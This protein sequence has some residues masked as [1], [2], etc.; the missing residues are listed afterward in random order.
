MVAR[1]RA[2]ALLDARLDEVQRTGGVRVVGILGPPG[3]GR[4]ALM[5]AFRRRRANAFSTVRVLRG[6]RAEGERNPWAP[7]VQLVRL[8]CGLDARWPAHQARRAAGV[9]LRAALSE[10]HATTLLGLLFAPPPWIEAQSQAIAA[11]LGAFLERHVREGPLL[12]LLEDCEDAGPALAVLH[13]LRARGEGAV[14]ALCEVATAAEGRLDD[15]VLLEALDLA[16]VCDLMGDLA[17]RGPAPEAVGEVVLGA[18]D[19]RAGAVCAVVRAL[20]A[21]GVAPPGRGDW[22]L[23]SAI[24]P[25]TAAQASERR[26]APLSTEHRALLTSA[27]LVGRHFNPALVPLVEVEGRLD[28]PTVAALCQ[29]GVVVEEAAGSLGFAHAEDHEALRAEVTPDRA[30]ASHAHIAMRLIRRLGEEAAAAIA[31]HLDGAGEPRKAAIWRLI[32]ARRA[33]LA[34]DLTGARAL[35]EAVVAAQVHE[36]PDVRLS[37][38]ETLA[39]VAAELGDERAAAR[40]WAS[41]ADAGAAAGDPGAEGRGWQGTAE[42]ALLRT[43]VAAASAAFDAA[44]RL[45]RQARSPV[46]VAAAATGLGRVE[47][48][49]GDLAAAEQWLTDGLERY[50]AEDDR[51]GAAEVL[52]SMAA[53]RRQRGLLVDAEA[54]LDAALGWILAGQTARAERLER[55]EV[56]LAGDRLEE[57]QAVLIDLEAV[58]APPRFHARRVLLAARVAAARLDDVDARRWLAE[59]AWHGSVL[60]D[61]HLDER[62]VRMAALLDFP[63]GPTP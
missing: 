41:V 34:E 8:A 48:L 18:C 21:A 37:G 42:L 9:C 29:T 60:G 30:V 22:I 54:A 25:L 24:P 63:A 26:L 6:H 52:V 36:S 3:S 49:R 11:A 59:A 43:E 17:D 57:A 31:D 27:A 5:S 12:L 40:G 58:A 23:P 46:A 35:A 10:T 19:G 56:L 28:G 32:A 13:A 51:L 33:W 2:L 44:R 61:P 62:I 7:L 4:S 47:L 50:A 45:A 14:L 55:A 20:F 1:A 16:Q 38:L 53:L 39:G 15:C